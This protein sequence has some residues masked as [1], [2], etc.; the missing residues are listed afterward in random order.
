MNKLLCTGI[1]IMTLGAVGTLLAII[2]EIGT[3]EPAYYL[4]MKVTAG[5]FGIGGP[6]VGWGIARSRRNRK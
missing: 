2:L 1:V 5:L 3:G 4:M 6:L